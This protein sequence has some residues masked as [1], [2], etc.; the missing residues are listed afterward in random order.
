M[1]NFSMTGIEIPYVVAC[2]AYRGYHADL[3]QAMLDGGLS[4]THITVEDVGRFLGVLEGTFNTDKPERGSNQT[5]PREEPEDSNQHAGLFFAVPTGIVV[6][7]AKGRLIRGLHGSDS[8]LP[9]QAL[10]RFGRLYEMWATGYQKA[11]A[12]FSCY[13]KMVDVHPGSDF[14]GSRGTKKVPAGLTR[15]VPAEG[16]T[17]FL[18]YT[19]L[20]SRLPEGGKVLCSKEA[21]EKFGK[22]GTEASYHGFLEY[23]K[24]PQFASHPGQQHWVKALD[25]KCAV[26]MYLAK[27]IPLFRDC[28]WWR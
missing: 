5:E 15:P 18:L 12:D 23:V 6:R 8:T 28:K 3:M 17:A 14:I 19:Y 22:S 24:D 2:H 26:F 27:T 25:K 7:N 1:Q 16:D 4:A 13:S 11:L 20:L 9:R 21:L 10:H